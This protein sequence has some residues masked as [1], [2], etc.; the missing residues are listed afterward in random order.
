M[1]W[2]GEAWGWEFVE[3]VWVTVVVVEFWI[4]WTT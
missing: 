1:E 4:V 2:E 3:L